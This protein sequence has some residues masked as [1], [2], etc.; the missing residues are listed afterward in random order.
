MKKKKNL[1]VSAM[2]LKIYQGNGWDAAQTKGSHVLIIW[3][4]DDLIHWSEPRRVPVSEEIEAGCTWAPEASYD[5]LT[6]EYIV[7]LSSK[8][9]SDNYAKQRVYITRTRDFHTFSTLKSGST[10]ISLPL[11]PPFWNITARGTGSPRMK[12]QDQRTGHSHQDPVPGKI[13][14]S[15]R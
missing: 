2:D 15:V 3:E 14:C 8:T 7:Y 4:S 1:L 12:A 10:W 5:P 6:E 9:A 11:T 13:R